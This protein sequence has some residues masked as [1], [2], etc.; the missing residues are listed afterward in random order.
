MTEIEDPAG[1]N[2]DRARLMATRAHACQ[3]DKASL[4]YIEHP[5]RV[6]G[7]LVAPSPAEATVAWLHDVVE[8]TGVTLDEV[9]QEFGTQV[10]AAVDAMSHRVGPTG[11]D[12]LR[13]VV[14]SKSASVGRESGV[15]EHEFVF[16]RGA[17]RWSYEQP[18][19]SFG[20]A[21][22]EEVVLLGA[23]A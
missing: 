3:S 4:A 18:W 5:R 16:D 20:G 22:L 10:A 13:P 17:R 14:Q 11:Q 23:E 1:P 15:H 21:D 9:E 6:V 7:H 2:A 12:E 19:T 8:D